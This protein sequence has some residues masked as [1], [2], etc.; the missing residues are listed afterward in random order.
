VFGLKVGQVTRR[1]FEPRVR[2]LLAGQPRLLGTLEPLLIARTTLLEQQGVVH[3]RL[4]AV[5]R[6]DEICRRLMTVPG[7]GAVIAAAYRAGVDVP[8]R[9][10]KSSTVGAHFG[11]SP[12]EICLRRAR[13]DGTHQQVRR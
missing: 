5:V 9:F 7:V 10:A 6:A 3:R 8:Q 11:L 1:R 2:E 12:R 4:L 13:P